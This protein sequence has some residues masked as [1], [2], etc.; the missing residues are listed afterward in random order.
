MFS[1]QTLRTL[2][3]ESYVLMG[4]LC[5]VLL[6]GC[7]GASA[8]NSKESNSAPAPTVTAGAAPTV[9]AATT[10][11][12]SSDQAAD[13]DSG[14]GPCGDGLLTIGDLPAVQKDWEKNADDVI[15]EGKDWKDDSV[16]VAVGPACLFGDSVD[17]FATYYSADAKLW[18]VNGMEVDLDNDAVPFAP[19]EIDFV[20][21][22]DSLVAGGY[23]A[24]RDFFNFEFA[25]SH[26]P[27]GDTSGDVFITMLIDTGTEAPATLVYM[28]AETGEITGEY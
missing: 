23:A 20:R 10:A 3:V 6:A 28:N 18:Q 13:S 17:W 27:D 14:D 16:L 7:G 22:H 11:S 8:K 1:L 4:L 21:V 15:K 12:S 5:A 2:R 25:R 24:D 19:D 9:A 26:S